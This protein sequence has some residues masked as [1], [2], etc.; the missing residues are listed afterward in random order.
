[1]EKILQVR[2]LN[3]TFGSNDVLKG[4]S[5]DITRNNVVGFIGNNGAGKS[6]TMKIILGL[7][8]ADYG[9]ISILGEKVYYGNNK[10]NRYIG[11]LPDVPAFYPYMT[12]IEYLR[13]CA[14]ITGIAKFEINKRVSELIEFVGLNKSAKRKINGFSRGMKQRLGIAQA[15]VHKPDLLICDEPTSALDPIGRAE[16]LDLLKNIRKETTVFFSTHILSDI[17]RICDDVVML[18]KGKIVLNGPIE[19]LKQKNQLNDVR[20]IFNNTQNKDRTLYYLNNIPNV[21][22]DEKKDN[23]II[24]QLNSNIQNINIKEILIAIFYRE[25]IFPQHFEVV[26]P[27]LEDIFV[28]LNSGDAGK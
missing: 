10:T 3:K 8:K 9:E 27:T 24:V 6:T 25:K 1:M 26:E 12:P 14:E 17:E 2:N 15:I 21:N 20:I 23:E 4:L 28:N 11:Y 19:E 5:F 18:E 13:L 7:L 16:I 22:V